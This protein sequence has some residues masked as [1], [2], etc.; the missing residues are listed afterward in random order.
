MEIKEMLSDKILMRPVKPKTMT[1]GGIAIPENARPDGPRR[2]DIV[3]A[4][5]GMRDENGRV[6]PLVLKVGERVL[7]QQNRHML[8]VDVNGE[9]MWV[10]RESDVIAVEDPT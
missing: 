2:A 10:G 4:G 6:L 5:P 1:R 7:L 8:V 9:D 3:A